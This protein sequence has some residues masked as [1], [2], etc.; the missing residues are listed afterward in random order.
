MKI[1]DAL[2]TLGLNTAATE[3]DVKQAYRDLAKIWHPDRFQNDERLNSRTEEQLKLINEAKTVALTYLEKHGHFLKAGTERPKA[4]R[5]PPGPGGPAGSGARTRRPPP[6]GSPG[7]GQ[8]QRQKTYQ[9]QQRERQQRQRQQAGK[10]EYERQK[11]E[12]A[13][14][15]A[16]SPPP[17]PPREEPTHVHEPVADGFN[18]G[19]SALIFVF[20]ALLLGSFGIMV[21]TSLGESPADKVK[22]F[23]EKPPTVTELQRAMK[24]RD[25]ETGILPYTEIVEEEEVEPE[26][27]PESAY[28]DTFF[29]LGSDKE[30]VSNVQGPPLQIKGDLW[31]YGHSS[32]VFEY[33]VV[34]GWNSSELNP[35]KVGMLLPPD[36]LFPEAYFYVGSLKNEVVALQGAPSVIEGPLWKYGEATVQFDKDTVLTWKNDLSNTLRAYAF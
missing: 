10:Q 34:I 3:A 31:Q 2:K 16:K 32:V 30:W 9:E 6:G 33:G 12:S 26:P 19:Q 14:G 13:E 11:S 5:P 22:K 8:Q 17:P 29:T 7:A 18:F 23:T 15:K 4:K 35:L 25:E 24:E 27:E 21:Y 28:S 1:L 36:E 20:V